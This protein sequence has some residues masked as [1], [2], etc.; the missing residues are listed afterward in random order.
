MLEALGSPGAFGFY[1]GLNMAAFV[2][3]F[4]LVPGTL[5]SS[6]LL[7]ASSPSTNQLL[8]LPLVIKQK[9]N[10]ERSKNS[11]TSSQ[12]PSLDMPHTNSTN[13]YLTLSNAGFSSIRAQS[14]NLFMTLLRSRVLVAF[15][16]RCR[17][18]R[19]REQGEKQQTNF[20]V[21]SFPFS[22][23][24]FFQNAFLCW[25]GEGDGDVS[26]AR[27]VRPLTLLSTV[28][29]YYSITQFQS[30][31]IPVSRI[32]YINRDI[33]IAKMGVCVCVFATLSLAEYGIRIK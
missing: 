3:I 18:K 1:A 28:S 14:L 24:F 8:T 9:R 13:P 27:S 20:S 6:S 17:I 23:F 11:T 4:F 15:L 12:F 25:G 19:E 5:S 33:S 7:S 22:F 2:M 21:H 10:N 30:G 29:L 31:G 16:R 26:D 32:D